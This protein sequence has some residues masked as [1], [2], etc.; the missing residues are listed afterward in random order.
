MV[1]F[2]YQTQDFRGETNMTT[3]QDETGH[4][5]QVRT[6]TALKRRGLIAG[7][8]ALVAGIVAKQTAQPVAAAPTYL[9]LSN[10]DYTTNRSMAPTILESVGAGQEAFLINAQ[11]GA[12]NV[13]GLH[14]QASPNGTGVVG[15]GGI[16]YG[17]S[18]PGG[19]GVVGNGGGSS[20]M[21]G[22]FFGNGGSGVVGNGGVGNVGGD[23]VVAMGANGGDRS[24]GGHGGNGVSA[25]AGT[26]P[27]NGIGVFSQSVGVGMYGLSSGSYGIIGIT[28][29][30]ATYSGITGG[31]Q[32]D[33]A[34]AVAGGTSN[35][36]A[37]A[38]YFTGNVVV[39]GNFT[40][41]DPTK[42]HG[43]IKA[44]TGQYHT[45]YSV[46][47]PEPWL[48]DFGTGTLVNGKVEIML[49]PTFADVIHT[50]D[51]HVFLTSHD[52][53]SRGLA[54]GTRHANGFAVQEHAGGTFSYRVVARPKSDNKA[55][56]LATFTVPN[57]TI[58]T[59]ADLPKPP[60]PP[61]P[62]KMPKKP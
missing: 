41:I 22:F 47:S 23:G 32:T 4:I 59:I 2:L 48:E 60:K 35:P 33:G 43:A 25:F 50:E 34:A 3:E 7:A 56:R 36:K 28:T 45:L 51:Y 40:V 46:E 21:Q 18:T 14:A 61:E 54:V 12:G 39:D 26:G 20:L 24:G 49:D 6:G 52:P 29:A 9:T 1:S 38:G 37:Y 62:P 16:T 30:G 53:Q 13:D 11:D 19:S 55:A 8:A 17:G 10:N 42:K 58:P 27:T 57:I 15:T 5:E 44:S 31:A